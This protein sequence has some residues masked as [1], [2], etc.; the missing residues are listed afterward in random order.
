VGTAVLN[1]SAA[2]CARQARARAAGYSLLE[3]V[4]AMPILALALGLFLGATGAAKEMRQVQ[5]ENSAVAEEARIVLERMRNEDWSEVY[6]LYNSTPG[7]DPGGAGTA[8]G[9]TFSIA[10]LAPPGGELGEPVGEILM[11][12]F[13]HPTLGWQLR[14]DRK[15]TLLG[16]PR[17]LSGDEEVDTF[18]HAGDYTV[19]PVVVRIT[20]QGAYGPREVVVH[21]VMTEYRR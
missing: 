20:W 9:N 15:D 3:V 21:T 19:L 1:P 5:R 16:M 11:P 14:E 13:N 10:G 2:S 4:V 18:N 7:D 8:P 12:A 17:D 6:A